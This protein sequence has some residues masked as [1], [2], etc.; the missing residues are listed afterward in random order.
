MSQRSRE[1]LRDDV[2]TGFTNPELCRGIEVA[3]VLKRVGEVLRSGPRGNPKD[4]MLSRQVDSIDVFLSH[5]WLDSWFKK[6]LAINLYFNDTSATIASN[7]AVLAAGF[8]QLMGLLPKYCYESEDGSIGENLFLECPDTEF[9]RAESFWCVASGWVTY[10]VVL[11]TAQRL[12]GL[13]CFTSP[14]VF[15]DK[16]CIQQCTDHGE[17]VQN[18][19]RC[20]IKQDGIRNLGAFLSNSKKLVILYSDLY[21]SRA[22]CCYEYACFIAVRGL[23]NIELL[24]LARPP[25]IWSLAILSMFLQVGHWAEEVWDAIDFTF[26]TILLLAC[27]FL[28]VSL[29]RHWGIER[30]NIQNRIKKFDIENA[31]CKVPKDK[32][33]IKAR[34]ANWSKKSLPN[35]EASDAMESRSLGRTSVL[36]ATRIL[37]RNSVMTVTESREA[38]LGLAGPEVTQNEAIKLFNEYIQTKGAAAMESCLGH[39]AM[40][41]L[42]ILPMAISFSWRSLDQ[43]VANLSIGRYRASDAIVKVIE[44]LSLSFI[45]IPLAISLASRAASSFPEVRGFKSVCFCILL[46]IALTGMILFSNVLMNLLTDFLRG[47]NSDGDARFEYLYI[48]L[49]VDLGCLILLIHIQGHSL[50]RLAYVAFCRDDCVP[51]VNESRPMRQASQSIADSLCQDDPV[52][53]SETSSC[54]PIEVADIYLEEAGPKRV[55]PPKFS[56]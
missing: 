49:V 53:M 17:I 43:I 51:D 36:L 34:I 11:C 3:A 4:Y 8:G 19:P 37:G 45:F 47:K 23:D 28:F 41:Y 20:R 44:A 18:C 48:Y 32:E 22:W 40:P 24:P 29:C 21:F 9:K 25:I 16:V 1:D 50:A 54:Y 26:S 46:S 52:D 7:V 31:N 35:G 12:R 5:V 30:K 14:L 15:L 56:L 2:A 6:I 10:F 27:I 42:S 38:A 33:L 55:L 13:F 39:N